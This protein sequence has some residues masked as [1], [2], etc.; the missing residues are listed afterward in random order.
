MARQNKTPLE[1]IK[2][3][4]GKLLWGIVAAAVALL[5]FWFIAKPI[6]QN[7]F[8]NLGRVNNSTP[9]KVGIRN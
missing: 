4:L 9:S 5:V 8:Q 6:L 7:L 2:K 1:I 3:E